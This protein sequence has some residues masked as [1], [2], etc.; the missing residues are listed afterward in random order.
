MRWNLPLPIDICSCWPQNHNRIH[1]IHS[2]NNNGTPQTNGWGT[3][4]RSPLSGACCIAHCVRQPLIR[5]THLNVTTQLHHTLIQAVV[6]PNSVH[7]QGLLLSQAT[8]ACCLLLIPMPVFPSSSHSSTPTPPHPH[9][10]LRNPVNWQGCFEDNPSLM[11]AILHSPLRKRA[12]H[13]CH[14]HAHTRTHTH[15]CIWCNTWVFTGNV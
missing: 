1:T 9:V 15:T 5:G 8:A 3:L 7:S 14:T 6:L 4:V 13:V 10:G 12:G 11:T 2:T